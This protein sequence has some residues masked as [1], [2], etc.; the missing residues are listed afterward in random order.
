VWDASVPRILA[1]YYRTSRASFAASS[2][3]P[4]RDKDHVEQSAFS[5]SYRV[6]RAFLAAGATVVSPPATLCNAAGCLL[7]VPGTPFEPMVGDQTHLTY[8][9]SIYFV[10]R[11]A[12]A[13][14]GN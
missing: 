12:N 10:S 7:T 3:A 13:M 11:N 6:G 8:A 5:V 2:D 4:L 9:G 14:T 1:R